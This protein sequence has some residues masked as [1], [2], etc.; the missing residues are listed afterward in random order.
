MAYGI[1][2]AADLI[3]TCI[4][5]SSRNRRLGLYLAQGMT[6]QQAVDKVG[7]AVEGVAMAQTIRTLW[8]LNI[9]IPLIQ[10]VNVILEGRTE[11]IRQE[12]I[13]MIVKL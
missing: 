8:S 2:G 4:S 12:V 9:A 1:S 5:S 6:L 10:T 13:R 7:M 11:D 3:A